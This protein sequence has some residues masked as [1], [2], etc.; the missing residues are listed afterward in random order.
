MTTANFKS[1]L[2]Y[3]LIIGILAGLL[4]C[5]AACKKKPVS[6]E[7]STSTEPS[8][9]VTE[10]TEQ[11]APSETTK[12][13][14][15]TSPPE[16]TTPTETTSPTETTAT[17]VCEHILSSWKVEKTS[18]CT[19]EGS[20]YK[21]CILCEQKVEEEAIP[22]AA[23]IPGEWIIDKISTCAVEGL[24]HQNCTQCDTTLIYIT[25]KDAHQSKL[26]LGYPATSENPGLT[27]G[28][29]CNVCGEILVAQQVIPALDSKSLAY[30]INSD[31]KTCTIS[32][33]GTYTESTVIVPTDISGYKVT[34]IGDNAFA[35]NQTITAIQLPSTVTQ[36]GVRVFYNCSNLTS[37]TY[38]GTKEQWTAITKGN[39][40]NGQTGNYTIICQDGNITS[41]N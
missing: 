22:K 10:T 11:T 37:I 9:S 12:P 24:Q 28:E 36:I 7:P 30:S 41:G 2:R 15:T 14:E 18:T 4:F 19:T 21:E 5:L 34:A 16:T 25:V 23:H 35:N 17:A 38:N 32:G 31:N 20:R 1:I 29:K 27:D 39:G 40:W 26:I 8:S 3:L 33:L 13:T 6:T